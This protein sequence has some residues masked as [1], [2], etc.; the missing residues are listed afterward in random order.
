[1]ARSGTQLSGQAAETLSAAATA[2]FIGWTPEATRTRYKVGSVTKAEVETA[3]A[4]G[5]Q[6]PQ[7]FR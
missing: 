6:T 3:V 5:G 2:G 4:A 1:M 7:F